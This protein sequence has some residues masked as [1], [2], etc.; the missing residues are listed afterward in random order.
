MRRVALAIALAACTPDGSE[1]SYPVQPT[2]AASFTGGMQEGT[3]GGGGGGGGGDDGEG[4][5]D[6]M[7]DPDAGVGV[8]DAGVP[9]GRDAGPFL[10]GGGIFDAP[11]PDAAALLPDAF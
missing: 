6:G 10:D 7:F 1:T 5:D 2:G 8:F 3:G 9:T 4:G 11:P